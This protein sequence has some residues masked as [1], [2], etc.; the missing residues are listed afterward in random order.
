MSLP[1]RGAWIEIIDDVFAVKSRRGRSPQ[2]ERGLKFYIGLL[3]CRNLKSLP[4][5]GAW[6]EIVQLLYKSE[7]I[8]S[9]PARGAWIVIIALV[10]TVCK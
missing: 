8:S 5:R 9:L 7:Y 3:V 1:A 10:R 2:G 4:A 6:I